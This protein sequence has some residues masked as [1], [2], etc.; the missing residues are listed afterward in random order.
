MLKTLEIMYK[1]KN[2]QAHLE[3][4]DEQCGRDLESK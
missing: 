2:N 4:I 1:N 3:F